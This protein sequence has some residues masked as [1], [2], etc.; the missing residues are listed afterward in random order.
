MRFSTIKFRCFIRRYSCFLPIASA[1]VLKVTKSFRQIARITFRSSSFEIFLLEFTFAK[2]TELAFEGTEVDG[3]E[4]TL[5]GMEV[6]TASTASSNLIF[7]IGIV[8]SMPKRGVRDLKS[9][10][11]PPLKVNGLR[12]PSPMGDE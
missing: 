3:T 5:K 12:A 10:R 4:L 9:K 1:I 2:G 11:R 6:S 8:V 7:S